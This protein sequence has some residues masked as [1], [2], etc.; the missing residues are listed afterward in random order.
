M[1]VVFVF[2]VVVGV[3]LGYFEGFVVVLCV[4][5]FVIWVLWLGGRC[6]VCGCLGWLVGGF[7]CVCFCCLWLCLLF[8]FFK[9]LFMDFV[10]VCFYV[11]RV[12]GFGGFGCVWF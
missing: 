7:V 10:D 4:F 1:F 3:G 12:Y 11:E 2:V 5:L 8:F 6:C 9:S